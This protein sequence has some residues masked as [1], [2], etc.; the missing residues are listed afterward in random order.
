MGHLAP[1]TFS[2]IQWI[3]TFIENPFSNE[4]KEDFVAI[5]HQNGSVRWASGYLPR[6][7]Q[8]IEKL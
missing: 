8:Q 6:N 5:G 1:N 3:L 7:I 2:L 4:S